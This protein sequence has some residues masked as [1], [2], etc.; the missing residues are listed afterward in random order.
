MWWRFPRRIP[1]RWKHW[2]IWFQSLFFALRAAEVG[3]V[4][5]LLANLVDGAVFRREELHKRHL[6]VSVRFHSV[7][8]NLLQV[9][10]LNGSA[11][12]E[13]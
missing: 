10:V 13:K 4:R 7:F 12:I 9:E 8:A 1:R 11:L 3:D 2:L 6:R 5:L